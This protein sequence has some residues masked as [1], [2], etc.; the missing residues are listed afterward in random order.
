MALALA[1]ATPVTRAVAAPM[2]DEAAE[3]DRAVAEASVRFGLSA[4]LIRAVLAT[5][6]GGR[7]DAVSP[8]G[9][10][11]LMQLMP[12]AWREMRV[13]LDLG[14]DPFRPRDNILAGAGYLRALR[15]RF[16]SPGDLA[17]YNAGPGRYQRHLNGAASLPRE[18]IAYVVR[19]RRQLDLEPFGTRRPAEDWRLSGLF[20]A[21]VAKV[22]EP[23]SGSP[24]FIPSMGEGGR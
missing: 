5:E 9:A 24:L 1:A 14:G 12:A 19:I 10:M 13:E 3:I 18:T 7:V 21:P 2:T 11:G 4:R 8:K 6:S 16:G 15:D 22:T 20:A 17:A 23:A